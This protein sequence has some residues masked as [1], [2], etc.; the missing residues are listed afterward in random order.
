MRKITDFR[1]AV[2]E[3]ELVK[4]PYPEYPPTQTPLMLDGNSLDPP[5]HLSRV[6]FSL[7]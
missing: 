4:I 2:R 6:K 3:I 1:D 5:D 7:V